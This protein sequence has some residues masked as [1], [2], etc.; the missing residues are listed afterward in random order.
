M[1]Y[2][3]HSDLFKQP[4]SSGYLQDGISTNHSLARSRTQISVESS[5]EEEVV[6]MEQTEYQM[7]RNEVMYELETGIVP[8]DVND[9]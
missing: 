7:N 1:G 8:R 3:T 6:S 2:L 5:V 4:K 9:A